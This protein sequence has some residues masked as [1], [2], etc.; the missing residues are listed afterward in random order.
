MKRLVGVLGTLTLATTATAVAV[1]APGSIAP[2]DASTDGP[3]DLGEPV[4]A[5]PPAV[6]APS[7]APALASSLPSPLAALGEPEPPVAAPARPQPEVAP[8]VELKPTPK[9]KAVEKPKTTSRSSA[10][11]TVRQAR[12]YA[13]DRVGSSQFDCLDRLWERESSWNPRAVN[14]SSGAYGIPQALPGSKMATVADDWR[15]NPVT[16]VR[17]GLRYIDARYGS[18]CGAWRHSQA[19]GWY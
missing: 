16:Q 13:R 2:A 11:P 15:T 8:R 4:A 18:P 9:P 17:W 7:A 14:R 3:G 6:A 19:E 12:A 5:L 1:A 10:T